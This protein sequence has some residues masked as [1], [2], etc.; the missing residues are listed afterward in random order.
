[1]LCLLRSSALAKGFTHCPLSLHSWQIELEFQIP[2][3]DFY[4]MKMQ[5]LQAAS[6]HIAAN[7]RSRKHHM[8]AV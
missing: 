3:L 1:M 6:N 5:L 2:A 7:N 4:W 8:Y